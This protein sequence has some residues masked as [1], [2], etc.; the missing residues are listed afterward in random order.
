MP[1]EY[2]KSAMVASGKLDRHPAY[3]FDIE[4]MIVKCTFKQA[5]LIVVIVIFNSL[6]DTKFYIFTYLNIENRIR[7]NL[8]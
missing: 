3:I 5:Q 8:K 1:D 7:Q 2:I 6:V 4:M